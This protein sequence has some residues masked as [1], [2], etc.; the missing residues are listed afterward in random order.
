MASILQQTT[1]TTMNELLTLFTNTWASKKQLSYPNI[2]FDTYFK[3]IKKEI[4][5]YNYNNLFNNTKQI[6]CTLK[7]PMKND[8]FCCCNFNKFRD[9]LLMTLKQ[10][11]DKT[12]IFVVMCLDH[13]A[14][15]EN[16]GDL[17]WIQFTYTKDTGYVY[18]E[19]KN[20][21]YRV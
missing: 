11:T 21:Y 17:E 19:I 20:P 1:T 9:S 4:D 10:Q 8:A 3:Q 12:Q 14:V 2:D 16:W 7:D 15:F 6:E 18:G 13:Y 5:S